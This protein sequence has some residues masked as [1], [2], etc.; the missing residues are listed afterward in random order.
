MSIFD[1]FTETTNSDNRACFLKCDEQDEV[2]IGASCTHMFK[3]PFKYNDYALDMRI[4]Y[5]QGLTVLFEKYPQDC[6]LDESETLIT[7]RLTPPET[8]K[9]KANG[10][11][12]HVQLKFY[13]REGEKLYNL[14]SK[15]K[16][17]PT[18]EAR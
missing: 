15:L 8:R 12:A 13:T 9:F 17:I 11:D 5:K 3:L 1:N 14:P 16:V 10:L 18:L 2:V 4:I 6:E 7:L